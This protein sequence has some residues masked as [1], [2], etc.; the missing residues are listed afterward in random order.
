M[1]LLAPLDW[2][3][4]YG[5]SVFIADVWLWVILGLGVWLARRQRRPVVAGAALAFASAYVAAMLVSAQAARTVVSDAWR[6][7]R[8]S[9]PRALMVGPAP[10]NEPLTTRQG[11]KSSPPRLSSGRR[12][13]RITAD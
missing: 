13:N 10:L 5:D 3:W 2:R 7:V 6:D 1:R 8:G 9:A 11:R 4:F 12:E